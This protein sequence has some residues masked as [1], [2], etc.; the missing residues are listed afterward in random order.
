[1]NKNL[2][3]KEVQEFIQKNTNGD[4]HQMLLRKTPFSSVSMQELVQQMKAR[5]TAEKKIPFL[6]KD[7]IHLQLLLF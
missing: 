4:F 1:M 7:C 2:L 3:N 5:K 6:I